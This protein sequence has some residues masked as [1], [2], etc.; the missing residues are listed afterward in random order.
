MVVSSRLI[1]TACGGW[2]IFAAMIAI[3]STLGTSRLEGKSK[4][5]VVVMKNGDKF[6]GE[7]KRLENGILYFKAEYMVDSVQLDWARVERLDSR[8]PFNVSLISGKRLIG[9]I[10]ELEDGTL[11]IRSPDA[12]I[13]GRPQEVVSIAPVESTVWKQLTGSVDYGFSFTGGTNAIQS[14][15]S[16][17]VSYLGEKWRSQLSGSSVFNYQSGARNSG[18]NNVYFQYLKLVSD[19]WFVG[20]T[21]SL[22]TSDEQDLTLRTN[23]GGAV[24]RDFI[25]SGTAGMFVLAG[26]DFSREKY[27][28]GGLPDKNSAEGLVQLQ[29]SKSAFRTLQFS[30]QVAAYPGLTTLG[31]L[32]LSIQSSLQREIV[33]NL[34]LKLSIYENYDNQPP[35]NAPKNDFGTSTSLG[36]KF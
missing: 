29:F 15:L 17:A 16:G 28:V 35:S 31:R 2:I 19:H 27:S 30:G 14:N 20:N 12:E 4:T 18:R 32:R 6:T 36:W 11:A 33:R 1:H 3:I 22:L 34:Y 9:V 8:D 26:V 7:I 25:N 5:D 24:G 13:Q 23:A 21:A 10:V